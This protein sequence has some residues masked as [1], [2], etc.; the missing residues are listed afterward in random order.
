M[1]ITNTRV[2]LP[3]DAY[4]ADTS[5]HIFP[6]RGNNLNTEGSLTR[7]VVNQYRMKSFNFDKKIYQYDVCH[8]RGYAI[9]SAWD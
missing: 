2:E 5:K 6:L 3:A 1:E 7:V 4:Q 8:G 9:C